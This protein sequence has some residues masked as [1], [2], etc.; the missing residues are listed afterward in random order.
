LGQAGLYA[1]LY[2]MQFA[3]E[4]EGEGEVAEELA[5]SSKQ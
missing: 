4:E 2:E 3:R 1:R 5:V